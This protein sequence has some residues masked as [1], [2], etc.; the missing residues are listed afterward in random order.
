[1]RS[2][3]NATEYRDLVVREQEITS[4]LI[5]ARNIVA[6]VRADLGI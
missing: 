6:A 3:R 5:H 1:M 2:K 4:D